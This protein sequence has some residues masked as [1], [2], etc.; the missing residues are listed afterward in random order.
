MIL[1]HNKQP[2]LTRKQIKAVKGPNQA[3]QHSLRKGST[4]GSYRGEMPTFVDINADKMLTLPHFIKVAKGI[5]FV[6]A[7][8][9]L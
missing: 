9:W 6:K 2:R 5:P 7:S 3:V 8:R 1:Q 4:Y